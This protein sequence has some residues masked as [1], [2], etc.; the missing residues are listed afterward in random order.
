MI[1]WQKNG[2]LLVSGYCMS[3]KCQFM[4]QKENMNVIV[5]IYEDLRPD[6]TTCCLFLFPPL[7]CFSPCFLPI[8]S[9]TSI[10]YCWRISYNERNQSFQ[11]QIR[12]K[13]M[14]SEKSF[15]L[16]NITQI[17]IITK[18]KEFVSSNFDG[19]TKSNQIVSRHVVISHLYGLYEFPNLSIDQ[20][21]QKFVFEVQC[22]I[23]NSSVQSFNSS[24]PVHAQVVNDSDP[25][26]PL[27]IDFV[28]PESILVPSIHSKLVDK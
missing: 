9:F 10:A 26:L 7:I 11:C 4:Y 17:E 18:Q 20:T 1:N 22:L 8:L 28:P 14:C 2:N 24:I 23:E 15:T 3:K 5:G 16:E 12:E 19:S 6:S 27:S 13:T 25:L 21:V